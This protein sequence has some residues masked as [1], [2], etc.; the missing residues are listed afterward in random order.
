MSKTGKR[1]KAQ[2]GHTNIEVTTF[3]TYIFQGLFNIYSFAKEAEMLTRKIVENK[4]YH[5][6]YLC[7]IFF[8]R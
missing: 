5:P 1:C 7:S 6:D 8:G 2:L 3:E 4:V